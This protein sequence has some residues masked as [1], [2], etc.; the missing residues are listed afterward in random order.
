[1][2]SMDKLNDFRDF[3]FLCQQNSWIKG[4]LVKWTINLI[5]N[6]VVSR[7]SVFLPVGVMNGLTCPL[8]WHVTEREYPR[9]MAQVTP[10][11]SA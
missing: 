6:E 11:I 7:V 2:E 8:V 5:A 10:S 4:K 3:A 9:G 1:M